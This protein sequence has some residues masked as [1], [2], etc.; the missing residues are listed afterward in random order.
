MA[1]NTDGTGATDRI[2]IDADLLDADRP[3]WAVADENGEVRLYQE[4]PEGSI[5]PGRDVLLHY[6]NAEDR[7]IGIGMQE[8]R[9]TYDDDLGRVVTYETYPV[10]DL[11]T[12]E[13]F[14][15]WNELPDDDHNSFTPLTLIN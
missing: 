13:E 15:M 9:T 3:V 2:N 1:R 4:D 14:E 10:I 8:E 5:E 12:G 6:D 11:A 7:P